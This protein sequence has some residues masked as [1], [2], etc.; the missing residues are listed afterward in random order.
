VESKGTSAE[1]DSYEDYPEDEDRDVND[2]SVALKIAQEIR[3]LGTKLFKEGK[4]ANA[5]E[6]YQSWFGFLILFF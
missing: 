5:L 1:G 6:K 2:P 3:E 4:T